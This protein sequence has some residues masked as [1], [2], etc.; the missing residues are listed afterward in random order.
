[1]LVAMVA[2]PPVIE[3]REERMSQ[4]RLAP[5]TPYSCFQMSPD[6][7]AFLVMVMT[8]ATQDIVTTTVISKLKS[9]YVLWKKNAH[10]T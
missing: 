7:P 9:E 1:M 6:P 3:D 10:Q 2:Q 5:Y 4:E 8:V